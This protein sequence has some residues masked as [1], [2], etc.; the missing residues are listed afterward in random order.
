MAVITRE[1]VAKVAFLARLSLTDDEL[2]RFTTQLADV[3]VHAQ[4][5]R[6]LDLDG[7]APTQHPFGL[8]NV[9]RHD[10]VTPCLSQAAV[11][12]GAPD[13]SEGRFLVPR[14]VGEAP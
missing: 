11:L 12:A 4:D 10:V 6:T 13:A 2:D 7:V 9:V 14:I 5:L 8:T 3:L 1:E